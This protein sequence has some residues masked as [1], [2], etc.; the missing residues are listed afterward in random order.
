M[1][2]QLYCDES[3]QTKDRYMVL[4]GIAVPQVSLEIMNR[5]LQALRHDKEFHVEMK[6]NK[7]SNK[8]LPKYKCL[9]DYFFEK[10]NADRLHFHAM[11]VDTHQV[12]HHKFNQ[13]DK[14]LGFYKFYYQ[15]L[16]NCFGRHYCPIVEEDRFVVYLD[17]RHTPY[18]LC[19][20]KDIL[21]HG[22][23]KQ[24]KNYGRPFR[25]VEPQN[26][27][28]HDLM[29]I[30]DVLIGAIGYHKNEYDKIKGCSPAKAELAKYIALL[31]GR[32]RLGRDTGYG[33]LRFK[34]WNLR[35]RE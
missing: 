31:S 3:R 4:G 28:Q 24:F 12:N 32:R 35:L 20:L 33:R 13:G 11:I 23:A 15:L 27:K 22:M 21:N 16:L 25:K 30:N 7:V 6:W 34:V 18:P 14:E 29:Q 2:R 8:W 1:I 26:S 5:E 19:E 9:V 17:Y 10:N